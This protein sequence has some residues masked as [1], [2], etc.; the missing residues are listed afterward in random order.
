M[1]KR[2]LKSVTYHVVV[3]ML[4]PKHVG[5][6]GLALGVVVLGG[7]RRKPQGDDPLRHVA[8]VHPIG[9]CGTPAA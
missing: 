7:T 5:S 8:E 9:C 3:A 4:V 2:K 6:M 1:A